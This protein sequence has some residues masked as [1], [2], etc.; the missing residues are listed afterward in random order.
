MN[1]TSEQLLP[2]QRRLLFALDKNDPYASNKIGYLRGDFGKDDN[3]F[4]STWFDSN[5]QL[6]CSHFKD[7]LDELI[8]ELRGDFELSL[9][10]N[11]K[12]MA[13]ICSKHP[14]NRLTEYWNT[15]TFGFYLKKGQYQFFVKCYPGVGDYNFYVHCFSENPQRDELFTKMDN[16][17][18]ILDRILSAMKIYDIRLRF[19]DEFVLQAEDDDGNHWAGTEFYDFVTNKCLCF[20]PEMKLCPGQYIEPNLLN[21]Y[22]LLSVSNGVIPG[23]ID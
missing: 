20:S 22:I 9:L 2:E 7:I 16:E 5:V 23:Q 11:R 18:N 3:E 13:D 4:Y 10:K 12:K 17:L 14:D 19:D 8:I 6:K 1:F 15:E 21:Q